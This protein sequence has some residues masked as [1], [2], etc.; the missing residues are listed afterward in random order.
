MAG[1]GQEQV[2]GLLEFL[3][4]SDIAEVDNLLVAA[5]QPGAQDVEPAAV[6]QLVRQLRAGLRQRER[7]RPAGRVLRGHAGQP[8]RGRVPLTDQAVAVQHRDAVSAGVDHRALMRA[9]PDNFLEGRHVGQRHAGVAGQQFEQFQLDMA[10]L[11]PA[12][13][14]VERAEGAPGHVRQA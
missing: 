5:A 10:D 3:G 12:V 13:E 9:L 4:G 11:A 2:L 14:R 6:L 1:G 7:K 8:V